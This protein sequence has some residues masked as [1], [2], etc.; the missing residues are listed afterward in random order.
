ML[1]QD[2]F[3]G[4]VSFNVLNLLDEGS[5]LDTVLGNY[6]RAQNPGMA[7]NTLAIWPFLFESTSCPDLSLNTIGTSCP[8][9]LSLNTIGF[10][11]SYRE[12]LCWWSY[13][14]L[15]RGR[16]GWEQIWRCFL[17]LR[18]H[19]D[20]PQPWGPWWEHKINHFCWQGKP[21][22]VYKVNINPY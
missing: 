20:P 22:Q 4:S 14:A 13:L 18:H 5:H 16:K 6:L 19:V 15:E 11:I 7:T 12:K 21:C 10:E 1:F 3:S 2:I 8:E 9:L 17:L